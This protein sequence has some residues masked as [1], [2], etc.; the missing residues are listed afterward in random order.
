MHL[1]ELAARLGDKPAYVLGSTGATLTYRELDER[2]KQ[3][4]QLFAQR[5]LVTGDS[6][7]ILLENRLEYLTVAWAAQRSG[8]YYAP[9]NWHLSPAE[10]AYIVANCEAKVL[11]SSAALEHLARAV[12]EAAPK[13]ASRLTVGQAVPGVER[14]EDAIAGLPAEPLAD[15]REGVYMFY[16]SGT[17]GQ[18]KGIKLPGSG[19]PFGTGHRI[20]HLM[21]QAFGFDEDTTFLVTGPLYHGAPL[22]WSLG[23]VRNGGTV[24]LMEKFDAATTLELI[25]RHRVTHAQFVPTM[26]VRMLKLPEEVRA[27]ADLSSLRNVIHAAAPCPVDVKEQI[28]EWFGPI[29]T[30]FY[31]G[32]EGVGFTMIDS[33]SW[34]AHKGSVGRVVIGEA[35]VVGPYGA[36]LP[37]GE[38]GTI[39]FSGAA[40]FEYHNEPEKTASAYDDKGW[41]TLGDIGHLDGEGFLYL[42]GR[43]TDL[44]LSGG[45]N[46]YPQ[47]IEDALIMHP[48]VADVAVV[49]VSDPEW[50]QRVHAV[51][52]A[53]R[54][55]DAGPELADTLIQHC[56]DTIAGY[57]V[58]RNVSFVD[59]LPRLP[60]GKIL[61]RAV[62]EQLETVG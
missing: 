41:A 38:I 17:T 49:G 55:E 48:A 45:V 59:D 2:S 6:V 15:E 14:L 50:G 52:Q 18:P 44:I 19:E 43:R 33:A 34:L 11:V 42:S 3:V 4:A 53:A 13:L 8:L 56:R 32:T 24:V 26:F 28:I 62:M 54:P 60:S 57:K 31:A 27:A 5:G 47:E 25:E 46:V 35:H 40:G 30:E 23:A 21:H 7:A 37:P 36:E 1:S 51:I 10:S 22:G 16:S 9:V 58:P 20:D 12:A 61:R 39:W 29:V